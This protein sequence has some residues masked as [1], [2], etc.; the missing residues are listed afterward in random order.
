MLNRIIVTLA[1]A[2]VIA[3]AVFVYNTMNE[4]VYT[5]PDEEDRID[6]SLDPIQIAKPDTIIPITNIS[7]SRYTIHPEASYSMSAMIVSTRRY[8]KGFMSKLSP[9]DYATIWGRTPDYL[10]YLKFDQIVRFCLF[11]T[12]HPELV[13]IPY[14]S[15]HMTNNHLIPATNNIRKALSIADAH[16]L[17][18]IE[19][20]LVNVIGQDKKN[21]FSYWNTSLTRE[22]RGN[23]A[24]EIIYVCKLRIND[25]IYE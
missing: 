1:I 6:I 10:P 11:K 19:G 7:G 15:S 17:V 22:D 5:I 12:K 13:D 16:D 25:K 20:Y 24:C 21:N 2:I 4:P 18:K 3:T 23:G 14:I 8:R 9:F